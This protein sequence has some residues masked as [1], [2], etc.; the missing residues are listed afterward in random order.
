MHR[1]HFAYIASSFTGTT[2]FQRQYP[3]C[4]LTLPLGVKENKRI[5]TVL[6]AAIIPWSFCH[7]RAL[8]PS[9]MLNLADRTAKSLQCCTYPIPWGYSH[10]CFPLLPVSTKS[11]LHPTPHPTTGANIPLLQPYTCLGPWLHD[12]SMN[13]YTSDAGV[14]VWVSLCLVLG[15]MVVL[16]APEPWTL[17][18]WSLDEPC[19]P[20]TIA[21]AVILPIPQHCCCHI[22]AHVPHLVPWRTTS[23]MI[24]LTRKRSKGTLADFVTKDTNS[25]CYHHAHIQTWS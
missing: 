18:L 17:A 25:P 11:W 23:A 12:H 9:L 19:I 20:D 15:A 16:K 7:Q 3:W 10:H 13:T 24:S 22:Y 1:K 21:T 5:P 4:Y 14:F 8:E 2:M 6:I